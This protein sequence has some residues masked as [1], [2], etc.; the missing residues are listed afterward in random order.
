M[1]MILYV[2]I[3]FFINVS[4]CFALMKVDKGIYKANTIVVKSTH[5]PTAVFNHQTLSELRLLLTGKMAQ[6]LSVLNNPVFLSLELKINS[7]ITS[8]E[9]E[10]ELISYQWPSKKEENKEYLVELN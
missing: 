6:K 1:Q 4:P 3:L 8:S 10:A 5:G 7:K 9:A 2:L